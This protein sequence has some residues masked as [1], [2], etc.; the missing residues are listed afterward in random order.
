MKAV[1]EFQQEVLEAI[2]EAAPEV[3]HAIIDKLNQKR[4][5]RTAVRF[6]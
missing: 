6:N 2:G 1:Q 4:A 3:R 5:I